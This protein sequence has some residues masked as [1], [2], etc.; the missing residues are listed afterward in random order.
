MKVATS[1]ET[2][3]MSFQKPWQLVQVWD[4]NSAR[5]GGRVARVGECAEAKRVRSLWAGSGQKFSTR[6]EFRW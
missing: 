3:C 2:R 5:R 1:D 6:P 4:R